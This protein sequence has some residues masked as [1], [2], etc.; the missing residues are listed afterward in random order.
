MTAKYNTFEEWF[1]ELEGFGTREERFENAVYSCDVLQM[2]VWLKQ[3]WELGKASSE[4]E[5]PEQEQKL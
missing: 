4:S 1:T 2:K 5:T 3:A